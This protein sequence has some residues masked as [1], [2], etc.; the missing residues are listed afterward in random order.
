M[1]GAWTTFAGFT[2]SFDAPS[3]S[4][5]TRRSSLI[6]LKTKAPC[7]GTSAKVKNGDSL[8]L[9]LNAPLASRLK[10]FETA[11]TAM[12]TVMPVRL[13]GRSPTSTMPRKKRASFLSTAKFS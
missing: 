1:T 2:V 10:V 13:S 11:P 12:F 7:T 3:A 9:D 8:A 6:E 4:K 5:P